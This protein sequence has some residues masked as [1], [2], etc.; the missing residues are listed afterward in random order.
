MAVFVAVQSSQCHVT[1]SDSARTV[2]LIDRRINPL[3][4]ISSLVFRR[5]V[6]ILGW[7]VAGA[8]LSQDPEPGRTLV[9]YLLSGRKCCQVEICFRSVLAVTIKAV[10]LEKWLDLV[11]E[12]LVQ[13]VRS[14][15][16][17]QPEREQDQDRGARC[18]TSGTRG[19]A[20]R[21]VDLW[22]RTCGS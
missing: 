22:G 6:G 14:R 21:K 13:V 12:L 10:G 2:N 9:T 19:R 11:V 18:D 3:L 7:H 15:C 16:D 5:L 8:Q 1:R 4:Q 17:R 20:Q